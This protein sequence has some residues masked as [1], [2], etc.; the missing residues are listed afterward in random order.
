[1]AVHV[2]NHAITKIEIVND[3]ANAEI[4][5]VSEEIF[6]RVMLAQNTDV[7]VVSGATVTSRA[8]LKAVENGLTFP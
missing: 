7:D 6:R 8:Y 1:V 2:S 5:G 3:I 4:T